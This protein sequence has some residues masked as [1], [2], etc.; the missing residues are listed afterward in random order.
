MLNR[1]IL[2][3]ISNHTFNY[4]GV[5]GKDFL[6]CILPPDCDYRHQTS[7]NL[8]LS[9]NLNYFQFFRSGIPSCLLDSFEK[10][11]ELK[12]RDGNILKY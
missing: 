9:Y 3:F 12:S 1:S 8:F 4:I 11:T 7:I 10:R 5:P 6:S 2:I